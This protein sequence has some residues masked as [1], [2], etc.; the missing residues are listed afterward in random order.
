M[1]GSDPNEEGLR[2]LGRT[3]DDETLARRGRRRGP[4]HA[5]R[6]LAPPDRSAE[7]DVADPEGERLGTSGGISGGKGSGGDGDRGRTPRPRDRRWVKRTLLI[8]LA[9]IVLAAGA[10]AGFAWYV[11]HKIHRIS[12]NGLTPGESSGKLANTQNILMVG[13]TTRCGLAKQTPAYGLCTQG[14]TGVN[15]DVVMI[16]HLNGATGAVSIL[17]I[18]RD[19]FIPNARSTTGAYKIDAALAQGPTQLVAAIEEDFGIPI[20]HYVELT[21]DSFAAVVTSLG[22]ITMTFP[23]ELFDRYSGLHVLS[24]G[25]HHLNGVQALQVVRARHL[26]YWVPGYPKTYPYTWP[27]EGLSDLARIVRDHEFL[28]VLA[29]KMAHQGLG[30]PAKDLSLIDAVAPHLTVDS[31]FSATDMVDIVLRFH[32][33][34]INQAPTTTLPVDVATFGPYLYQGVTMGDVE[35]PAE[36]ADHASIDALLGLA[37]GDNT[38]TGKPLPAPTGVTVSVL[39]GTGVAGQ[40]TQTAT[41]LKN[42]GFDTVGTGTTTSVGSYRETTV[43]YA[44]RTPTD[45]AAAQLVADSLS[46]QVILHYGP[47]ADG[48]QVTVTTGTDFHVDAT[49]PGHAAP[50]HP[51][52]PSSSSSSST[53]STSSSAT[54]GPPAVTGFAPTTPSHNP[55]TSYDPRACKPGVVGNVGNF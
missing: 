38:M 34:N 10:G 44:H 43:S 32:H 1:T 25:C 6:S 8:S 31:G 13:S 51:T 53:P 7:R 24:T 54:A 48:A 36:P 22:G 30:N 26:Q 11:N 50:A 35:F 37:P 18:P 3:I 47:T 17:S 23:D 49:L 21:F 20:Q 40:A 41:A 42:L 45:V 2:A 39:D 55:L 28:R 12:V 15:S 33:V 29:A 4:A 52:T 5:R 16:L 46:G 14:V 27:Q 9:V 19:L